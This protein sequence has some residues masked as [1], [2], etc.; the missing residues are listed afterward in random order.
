MVDLRVEGFLPRGNVVDAGDV[1]T[2]QV[3]MILLEKKGNGLELKPAQWV[4]SR[5]ASSCPDSR[6]DWV[7]ASKSFHP[8]LVI[9]V[10]R[11]VD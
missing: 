6:S 5:Q 10:S 11:P 9:H 2:N 1:D 7:L 4:E 3:L 8:D